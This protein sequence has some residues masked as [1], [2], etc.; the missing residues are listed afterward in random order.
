MQQSRGL[1]AVLLVTCRLPPVMLPVLA[2]DYSYLP[3][4]RLLW[5]SHRETHGGKD[6]MARCSHAQQ[7]VGNICMLK[8]RA[9]CQ[10]CL[11]V[12]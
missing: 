4:L 5:C 12:P 9:A 3:V 10:P 2:F 6:A 8:G 1:L 7:A 11:V